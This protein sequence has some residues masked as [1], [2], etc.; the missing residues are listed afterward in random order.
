ML[1]QSVKPPSRSTFKNLVN[2]IIGRVLVWQ[3]RPDI[4]RRLDQPLQVKTPLHGHV[5][6]DH[7]AFFTIDSVC[8]GGVK[9]PWGKILNSFVSFAP[10][11]TEQAIQLIP[12]FFPQIIFHHS[13]NTCRTSPIR[14]AGIYQKRV[15]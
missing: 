6:T 15:D 11:N 8:S 4:Q 14:I 7:R 3:F 2:S 9:Y 1:T 13:I 10:K 12:S 5:A